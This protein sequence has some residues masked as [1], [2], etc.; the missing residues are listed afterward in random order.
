MHGHSLT[1]DL[2]TNVREEVLAI[3]HHTA[4]AGVRFVTLVRHIPGFSVQTSLEILGCT[5][6]NYKHL[7]VSSTLLHCLAQEVAFVLCSE[8]SVFSA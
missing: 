3:A 4:F 6:Q 5:H 1:L 2:L 7:L 8:L